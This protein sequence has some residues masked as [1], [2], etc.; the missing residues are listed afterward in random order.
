MHTLPGATTSLQQSRGKQSS[1]E[2]DSPSDVYAH[3]VPSLLTPRLILYTRE[4]PN[5][6]CSRTSAHAVS[7]GHRHAL[8]AQGEPQLILQ[9]L[10]PARFSVKLLSL[11]QDNLLQLLP[12]AP[13]KPPPCQKRTLWGQELCVFPKHF[14]L[15]A[16]YNDLIVGGQTI[17]P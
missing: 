10:T 17:S 7:E 3:L 6:S 12:F 13:S 1:S 8:L 14:V 2:L 16:W 9:V 5:P 4:V 15:R 11:I